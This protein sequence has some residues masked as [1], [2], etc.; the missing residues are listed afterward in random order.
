MLSKR[1]LRGDLNMVSKCL[2]RQKEFV[3]REL[4]KVA[5]KRY[6][7]IQWIEFKVSKKSD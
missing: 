1:H 4:L 2:H 7:E 5:G 3:D 6:N